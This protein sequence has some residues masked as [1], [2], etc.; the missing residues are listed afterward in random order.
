MRIFGRWP[1][2]GMLENPNIDLGVVGTP[3]GA[4]DANVLF[5]GGFGIF[6]GTEHPE[7]AWKFLDSQ[8]TYQ[9]HESRRWMGEMNRLL[10]QRPKKE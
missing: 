3:A 2:S 10:E 6:S 7:A 9:T 4:V 8:I 5:W 1:Q